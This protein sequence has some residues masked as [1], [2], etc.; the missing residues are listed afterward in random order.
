MG[1][2]NHGFYELGRNSGYVLDK[3]LIQV[4]DTSCEKRGKDRKKLLIEEKH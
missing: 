1:R 2:S 4:V 3:E